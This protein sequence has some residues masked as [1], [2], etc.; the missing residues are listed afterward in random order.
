M[1]S[2]FFILLQLLA[3]FFFLYGAEKDG[4]WKQFLIFLSTVLFFAL[5]LASFNI[6]KSY[7]FLDSNGLIIQ[8][9]FSSYDS[10]FAYLN[11]GLG[12]LSLSIGIIKVIVFK[13]SKE[14][15]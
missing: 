12:L 4:T 7:A 1:D 5:S 2:I 15:L 6:E 8:E 10:T 3:F 13:D 14:G 9:T 11:S